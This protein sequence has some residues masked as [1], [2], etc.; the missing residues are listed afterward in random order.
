[1]WEDFANF[2]DHLNQEEVA[3]RDMVR[4]FVDK[5]I[6]PIIGKHYQ[7]GTFPMELVGQMGEYGLFGADLQGYGCA[8]MSPLSYAMICQELER[9]DTG[10]R[11]F[12]S[13]QSSLAMFAIYTFGSQEQKERWLPAMASGKKI[14]SFCLTEPDFGSNPGGMRTKAIENQD[15]Y[16]LNG[17]K[18]WIT[19]GSIA[20]I[21]IVWAKLNGKVKGFLVEKETP[22]SETSDIHNKLSLRASVT[23]KMCLEDCQVA[24]SALLP[25]AH[26][27]KAPF[28]CLNKARFGIAWGAIGAAMDCYQRAREYA[29]ARCQFNDQPLASHQLIQVKLAEMLT[30][31][32]K[33]QFLSLQVSRLLEKGAAKPAHISMIK[34][35]NTEMA[36][37]IARTARA[38]LGANGIVT[39][40]AVMRHQCNL[41]TAITYEGTSDI[42]RLI[43]GQAITG[44]PAYC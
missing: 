8:G 3:V 36:L 21:A 16:L 4:K 41:E 25:L 31:I 14:G 29:M 10:I 28:A 33:A 37:N 38:I 39:D 26:G 22:G 11:S 27:L 20:D 34:L 18:M 12:V 1:M 6:I 13:V 7:Q 44:I 30:E 9:G 43:L 2:D 5:T 32:C 40:Y 42:H 19:N 15:G 17:N 23:S 24:K 35:N